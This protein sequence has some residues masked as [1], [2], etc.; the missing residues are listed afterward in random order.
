MAT[1]WILGGVMGSVVVYTD[2]SDKEPHRQVG[3]GSMVTSGNLGG[4]MVSVV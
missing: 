3:V 2:L 1:S 4:V